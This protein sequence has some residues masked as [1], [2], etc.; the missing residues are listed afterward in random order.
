M[1]KV[2]INTKSSK[3]WKDKQQ[4]RYSSF[5]K[6]GQPAAEDLLLKELKMYRKR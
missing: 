6:D 2:N 4:C 5:L 1:M 3:T